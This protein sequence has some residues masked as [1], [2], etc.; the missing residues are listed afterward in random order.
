M[1]C[2]KKTYEGWGSDKV[3]RLERFA[4]TP[5]LAEIQPEAFGQ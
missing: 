4:A 5:N 2:K 3:N 1:Y